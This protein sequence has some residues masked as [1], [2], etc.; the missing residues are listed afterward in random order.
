MGDEAD[1]ILRS[2]GLSAEESKKYSV[3]KGKFEARIVPLRNLIFERAKFT[4]R[5]QED[6]ETV[7]A[8]I[9]DLYRLAEFCDYKAFQGEMT[10][11]RIVLDIRDSQLSEKLQM[12]PNLTLE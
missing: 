3:L 6:G 9:M 8:F 10:R 11:D 7:D 1:E 5:R 4:Q 12:D 2:F